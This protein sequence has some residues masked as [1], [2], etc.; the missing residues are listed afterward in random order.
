MAFSKSPQP[1]G[2]PGQAR[3]GAIAA[4]TA[5]LL[6]P[7]A[8]M[9]AFAVDYGY[10]L[11]ERSEL[12][13]MADAA[14][15]AAVQELVPKA[16]LSQDLAATRAAVRQYV[17]MNLTDFDAFTVLDEDI[18]IGRFDPATVFTNLTIVNDGVADTVRVTLRRDTATNPGVPMF[19]ARVLGMDSSD[20]VVTATAVLQK[21]RYLPPGSSVLPF[22][23]PESHWNGLP[24]GHVWSIYGDGH[25]EDGAGNMIPGNWGTVDIGIS[26]N[27]TRDL[28]DQ[29]RGGLYQDDLD[30]LNGE[31]RIPT[32]EY[33]DGDLDFY[34]NGDTGLSGGMR[35]AVA[36]VHG[37]TR[38]IPIYDDL[39]GHGGGTE[40]R[41]VDWGVVQVVN[42]EFRG[43]GRTFVEIKKT[44]LY[45]GDL[46]PNHDLSDTSHSISAAFTTPALIE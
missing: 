44:Y 46:R 1:T 19:F 12:Q 36:D 35:H 23:V 18:E 31:S 17:Q 40:F 24:E 27:S 5:L 2:C 13:R 22:S 29:I 42:S 14:A 6:I 4:T 37:Q 34:V 43:N 9:L 7:I 45:D 15:L 30:A 16:D 39:A 32:D 20:V 33:I 41:I 21:A 3:K 25:L 38:L 26:N 8:G 10:V 28:S 11:R